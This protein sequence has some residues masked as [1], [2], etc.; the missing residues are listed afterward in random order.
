MTDKKRRLFRKKRR[1]CLFAATPL[2]IIVRGFA[3]FLELEILIESNRLSRVLFN[4]SEKLVACF[5]P[6]YLIWSAKWPVK[7]AESLL[8]AHLKSGSLNCN[9]G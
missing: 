6:Q 1:L 5:Y 7:E 9:G 4:F 2:H 3:L 8:V